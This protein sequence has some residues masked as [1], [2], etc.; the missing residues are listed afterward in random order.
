MLALLYS[1]IHEFTMYDALQVVAEH[2][3]KKIPGSPFGQ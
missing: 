1:N 2:V 3:A